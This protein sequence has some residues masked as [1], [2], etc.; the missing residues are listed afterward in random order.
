MKKNSFLFL[1][2]VGSLLL[3]LQT[4]QAQAVEKG[5]LIIDAGIGG[6]NFFTYSLKFIANTYE[7]TGATIKGVPPIG[8]RVEYL[9]SDNFGLG[10]EGN[11]ATSSLAWTETGTDIKFKAPRLRVM[12]VGNFHFGKSDKLDWYLGAGMGYQRSKYTV[13]GSS[14]DIYTQQDIDDINTELKNRITIPLTGRLHFGT[15]IFFTD[16]I[17]INLEIGVGGGGIAKGG[18]SVKI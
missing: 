10:L 5:N 15:H 14:T 7:I 16:N 12:A 8:G 18:L 9:I 4:A 3:N 1:L 11:Y 2:L 6:P 17:G 13:E